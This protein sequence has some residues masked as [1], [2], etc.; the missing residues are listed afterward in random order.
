MLETV[1]HSL[2]AEQVKELADELT[3]LSK[4]QS[5]ALQ[6]GAYVVMSRDEAEQY[7]QRRTRI[8]EISELLAKFK[9]K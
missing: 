7:D 9:P 5:K 8:R 4:Q 6:A 2:T 3:V 1:R